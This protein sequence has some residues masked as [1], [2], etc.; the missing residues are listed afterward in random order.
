MTAGNDDLSVVQEDSD[1]LFGRGDNVMNECA[2]FN[3]FPC[4][5]GDRLVPIK[6]PFN[7]AN[8]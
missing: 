7:C 6:G 5:D 4:T 1:E 8:Y 2:R 3:E